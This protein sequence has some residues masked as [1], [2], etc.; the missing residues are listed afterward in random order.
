MHDMESA[1]LCHSN[2]FKS[3][4]IYGLVINFGQNMNFGQN[5]NF[6]TRVNLF[7]KGRDE[8]TKPSVC[9]GGWSGEMAETQ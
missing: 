9:R 1:K 5:V 2:I 8:H 4:W 7:V 6:G 3:L